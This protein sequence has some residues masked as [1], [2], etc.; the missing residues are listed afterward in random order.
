[1][2]PTNDMAIYQY[3]VYYRSSVMVPL[4]ATSV[5][6]SAQGDWS[7]PSSE[8]DFTKLMTEAQWS[9]EFPSS[10]GGLLGFLPGL[11]R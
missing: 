11:S 10:G 8:P 4:R 2:T 7:Q 3:T 9:P 5:A 1:M 6:G